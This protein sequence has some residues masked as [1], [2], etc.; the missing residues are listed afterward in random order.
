MRVVMGTPKGA[1][2]MVKREDDSSEIQEPC[3]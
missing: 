1:V 2:A 3:H